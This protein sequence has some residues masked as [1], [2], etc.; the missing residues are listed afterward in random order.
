LPHI[1]LQIAGRD[2]AKAEKSEKEKVR[3]KSIRFD[4]LHLHLTA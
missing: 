3:N 2:R 4:A 1:N